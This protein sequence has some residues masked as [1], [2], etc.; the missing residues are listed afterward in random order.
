MTGFFDM[1]SLKQVAII[2]RGLIL[3]QAQDD[4]SFISKSIEK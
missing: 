4:R 1:L 3:Q 2:L